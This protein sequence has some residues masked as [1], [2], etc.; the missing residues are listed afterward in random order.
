MTQRTAL[1]KIIEAISSDEGLSN[2]LREHLL[3]SPSQNTD[4]GGQPVGT[5]HQPGTGVQ[6]TNPDLVTQTYQSGNN[7]A[8]AAHT[9]QSGREPALAAHTHQSGNTNS[10]QRAGVND[11][12]LEAH[13]V[14]PTRSGEQQFEADH[15]G[16]QLVT[17]DNAQ[18]QQQVVIT[19][20][21]TFDPDVVDTEDD[22]TFVAQGVIT[23]YLEKLSPYPEQN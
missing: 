7:P 18:V 1:E 13:D 15:A 21:H 4:V 16:Q 12:P 3:P 9:H 19:A 20:P 6:Q 23:E 2:A 17:N 11:N 8:L 22:N 14:D 5:S 10:H